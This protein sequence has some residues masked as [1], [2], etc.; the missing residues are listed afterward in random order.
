[1]S[2]RKTDISIE[3]ANGKIEKAVLIWVSSDIVFVRDDFRKIKL[4][5]RDQITKLEIFNVNDWTPYI[6]LNH[7]RSFWSP[8]VGQRH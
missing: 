3:T 5:P 1:M 4:I 8:P 7:L 2:K 6:S